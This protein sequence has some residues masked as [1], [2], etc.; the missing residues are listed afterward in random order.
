MICPLN[1]GLGHAS[2]VFII[3]KAL[4]EARYRVIIGADKAAYEF[5][6]AE[7]PTLEIIRIRDI[8]IRYSRWLPAWMVIL[9][10]SPYFAFSVIREHC[11]LK[12]IIAELRPD[13]I[14][15]DN[16][17]GLWNNKILSVIITHQLSP[18]LP[19]I[20]RVFENPLSNL[21]HRMIRNFDYCWVPDLQ[22]TSSLSGKLSHAKKESSSIRYI[23]HLSRFSSLDIKPAEKGRDLMIIVSGPE[24]QRSVFLKI[25][26]DQVKNIQQNTLIVSGEPGKD[27]SY[28]FSPNCRMVSHLPAPEFMAEISSS[29]YV[30]CR[31]GYT[32]IMDLT[33]L[34][35]KAFLVPTP[36]QTEQEYLARYLQDKGLFP[37]LSQRQFTIES[38]IRITDSFR[39]QKIDPASRISFGDLVEEHSQGN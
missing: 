25:I 15:S 33:I 30:I 24:P 5:L 16:R 13:M 14:I 18:R 39:F 26:L 2:R 32:A 11:L 23:A 1:W 28:M 6:Q 35:K 36:G 22:G 19:A 17:Y 9:A 8:T 3:I 29:D 4:H 31:A 34:G 10:S 21:I 37:F 27:Y 12:K 38:A 20:L 7:F